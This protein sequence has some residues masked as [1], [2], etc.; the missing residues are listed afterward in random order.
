[1]ITPSF[2][3]Q[4]GGVMKFAIN[5]DTPLSR[6]VKHWQFCVGSCHAPM[7]Q[8]VDYIEQLK[9]IHNELGIE[10]VRFH[11]LFNDDMKV[12]MTLHNLVPLKAA[13]KFSQISFTQIGKIFDNVLSTGVR[14]F[15]E[16][17]FMPK[18]LASGKRKCSFEYKGNI[19]MP[20]S[21]DEWSNLI[22]DFVE[23]LRD[24]YGVNEVKEWYF[25]VWNEPNL[26]SFF[27]GSKED[28]FKLYRATALAIKSVDKDIKV[29]GPSTANCEWIDD[30]TTF[31]TANKVP[32]DFVSTHQY[33]GDPIG[34]VF[35]ISKI[36]QDV[37]ISYKQMKKSNGGTVL[38]GA[39]ILFK[40][41]SEAIDD[42]N[43]FTKNLAT[44][45]P[46]A[47]GLP[48]YYTE[49]NVSATCTA[50]INDT[51]RAASYA[52]R[53]ILNTEG[54]LAGTSWWTFSD[55]FEELQFFPEPFSGAFGMLNIHGIPKPSFY[56]FKL[57]SLLGDERFELPPLD[58]EIEAAAFKKSNT[59]QFLVY[60]QNFSAE[61]GEAKAY[62][63]EFEGKPTSATIRKIDSTHCNPLAI[64]QEMGS[65]S[66]VKPT[67]VEYIKS[68]SSLIQESLN[69]SYIDGKTLIRGELFNNDIHLIELNTEV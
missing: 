38:E 56:A 34:H 61:N 17:G 57:L 7:A 21:L 59:I 66:Y 52:I 6:H 63:I 4:Y 51:R 19:T 14:P 27:A 8:R 24:R 23:F 40:D 12:G 53:T 32:C 69:F 31:C 26:P 3:S 15:V 45:T 36:L 20:R 37:R 58:A 47:K 35:K 11:G 60:R 10:R 22:V 42:R 49:W 62:E 55:L 9:F 18:I 41:K 39:R 1:M 33:A 44:I 67:E 50:S 25:E 5:K 30:F 29:G 64:W 43:V 48:I 54:K 28:Y 65:P 68:R 16:L 13:R 2:Y 46:Q